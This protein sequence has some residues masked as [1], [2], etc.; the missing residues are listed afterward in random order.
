MEILTPEWAARLEVPSPTDWEPR[1]L[2]LARY[3]IDRYWL[4]A[5]SDF[6]LVSRVKFAIISCL[7]VKIL[8]GNLAETAQLYSKEIENSIENV[9]AILDATFDDPRFADVHIWGLLLL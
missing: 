9:E 4:Q 2:T 7:V 1:H 3:F 5:I 8:G 6:D